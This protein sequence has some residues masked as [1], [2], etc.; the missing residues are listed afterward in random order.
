[1]IDLLKNLVERIT[2]GSANNTEENPRQALIAA[3]VLL[4][5][6][7]TADGK[8]SRA[9]K[10]R[11]MDILRQEYRLSDD[12]ADSL[13]DAAHRKREDSIDIWRFTNLINQHF[14]TEQ[15]LQVIEMVWRIAYTDGKL[16]AHEDYLAHKLGT[17]LRLTHNELIQ[18]KLKVI[19]PR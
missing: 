3:C 7:A 16:D 12:E 5:E 13:I 6:M 2:Q 18:A 8:F 4:L 11:I 19:L 9:E 15:K 1:M 17:L 10:K 14:T